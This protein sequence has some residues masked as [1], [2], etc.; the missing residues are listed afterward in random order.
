MK[1]LGR[2]PTKLLKSAGGQ[3]IS[4]SVFLVIFSS[5]PIFKL[6]YM[7]YSMIGSFLT[8]FLG[9]FISIVFNLIQE[10]NVL[11]IT[12]SKPD[13]YMTKSALPMNITH[14]S[15]EPTLSARS[16]TANIAETGPR[17]V[18]VN[19]LCSDTGHINLAIRL[20]DE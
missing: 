14:K 1:D 4:T 18:A 3:K 10:R 15:G 13:T 6:S 11:N 19:G 9:W 17:N 12:S 2:L 5:W 20:D 7:W 8:I 16:T